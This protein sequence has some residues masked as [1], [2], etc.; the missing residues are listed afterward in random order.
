LVHEIAKAFKKPSCIKIL[1]AF[2]SIR[3][4]NT[5]TGAFLKGP[6][7]LSRKNNARSQ[8]EVICISFEYQRSSTAARGAAAHL[9]TLRE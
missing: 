5:V 6:H 8:R 9:W 1:L 4:V 7:F 3:G 2:S